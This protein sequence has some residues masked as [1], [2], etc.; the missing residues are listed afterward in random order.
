[1][2][3]RGKTNEVSNAKI[4]A[5][6]TLY[7][8]VQLTLGSVSE[9]IQEQKDGPLSIIENS[10]EGGLRFLSMTGLNVKASDIEVAFVLEQKSR[11]D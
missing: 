2:A 8:N 9:T 7:E 6:A 10:I 3:I 4:N 5:K 1:M 11:H